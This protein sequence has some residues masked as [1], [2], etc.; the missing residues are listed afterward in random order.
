MA[1]TVQVRSGARKNHDALS[2]CLR[3]FLF[4]NRSFA[5]F[6]AHICILKNRLLLLSHPPSEIADYPFPEIPIAFKNLYYEHQ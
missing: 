1:V 4:I 6:P 3:P 2:A 5:Q